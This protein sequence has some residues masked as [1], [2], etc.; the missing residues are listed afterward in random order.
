MLR[1]CPISEC[2]T[3]VP[4][5]LQIR[6]PNIMQGYIGSPKVT[7]DTMS[8]DGFLKTGDIGYIDAQGYIFLVDRAK[9]LIKV[10]G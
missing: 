6:G 8:D 4:G 2:K 9:E 1:G 7:Q 5:E 3:G 10:K